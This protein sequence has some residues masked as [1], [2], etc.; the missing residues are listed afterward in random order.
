[1]KIVIFACIIVFGRSV[2][3][4]LD[5]DSQFVIGNNRGLKSKVDNTE[6]RQIKYKGKGRW[7]GELSDSDSSSKKSRRHNRRLLKLYL[8]ETVDKKAPYFRLG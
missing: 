3:N 1:M 6:E 5:F 2:V 4:T 8:P 7:M